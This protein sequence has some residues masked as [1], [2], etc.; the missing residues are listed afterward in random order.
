M[1]GQIIAVDWDH[2]LFDTPNNRPMEGA[3]DA[4]SDLHERGHRVWVFSCNSPDWIRKMCDEHD[5][6]V[7]GIWG[8]NGE[9]GKILATVYIDDRAVPFGGDWAEAVIDALDLVEARP[10]K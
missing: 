6:R 1:A 8:E 9:T 5:L 10:V 7:D 2:T 3:R 4:L